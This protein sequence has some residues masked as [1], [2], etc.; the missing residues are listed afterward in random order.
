MS[1]AIAGATEVA[2][3]VAVAV[4]TTI[5][6]IA[7]TLSQ[8]T[9]PGKFSY[10]LGV[11][12][13]ACLTFSVVEA[14]LILPAH[15]AH[16]PDAGPTRTPNGVLRF[17]DRNQRRF[18]ARVDRFIAGPY[19]RLLEGALRRPGVALAIGCVSLMLAF[20]SLAGGWVKY[21]F[22][23]DIE[24][25][26]VTARL[27]MPEGTAPD[28]MDASMEH[29]EAQAI[30]L[31]AEL[32]KEGRGD[33]GAVVEH[34]LVAIGDAPYRHD[35]MKGGGEGPNVGYVAIGLVPGEDRTVTS[36]EIEDRWRSRVGPI[37]GARSLAFTGTDLGAGSLIDVSLWGPDREV[38]KR[39]AEALEAELVA[40]PGVREVTDSLRGGK[41]ELVLR[42]RPE[43]EALG[44]TLAELARQVRQGFHGEEVLRIQRGRDD[45]KVVVRYPPEERR[46]L[47]NL[48]SIRI[49]VPGGGELPF[50]AVAVAELG[51]GAS[52]IERRDRK[53]EVAVT[54]DI[55]THVVTQNEVKGLITETALPR[56]LA[57]YP[58]VEYSLLGSSREESE[59][60]EYLA[61]SW[62]LALIAA[63]AV[64]AVCLGSYLQP[65]LILSAIPF[66]FVG[67][68]IG[69]GLLGLEFC[70]F[71][72]VG[73]VA[74][75]GVVINDALVLFD[76]ANRKRAEGLD[77][78]DAMLEAG[79]TRFRAI[80]LTSL[81]TF[82]GLLPLLFERSAQAAWLKPMA[83]TIGFGVVFATVITLV[84]I[85]AAWIW[86]QSGVE[87]ARNLATSSPRSEPGPVSIPVS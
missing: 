82:F 58:G 33:G 36:L 20:G 86:M 5:L 1:A 49:R 15:L 22:F 45:V 18:D 31:G 16:N 11:V 51:R 56:I 27:V 75:T 39:A 32:R 34:V 87:W 52:P 63:Y 66:G 29:I 84:L 47:G 79:S 25:D 30:A 76:R 59:M 68:V 60:T 13:I 72:I 73:M 19:R 69:H 57:A 77:W 54:A 7:P 41:P 81:T 12:V 8:P 10:S 67:A 43:G 26:S 83:V 78:H 42:I 65:I 46:S 28:L 17:L 37:P 21:A 55:D 9:V 40:I 38:L 23:P 6:F 44:L 85:P 53:S 4:L 80:V 48:E 74:L 3:P 35:D 24:Y 50:P 62:L 14:L 64:L 61:R 2:R 71:S 70:A